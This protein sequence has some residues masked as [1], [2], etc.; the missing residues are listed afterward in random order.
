[1][2]FSFIDESVAGS[3]GPLTKTEVNW[4]KEKKGIQAILSVREGPL[5]KIWVEGLEYLNVPVKN[6]AVPTLAELN[7][8]V[9]YIMKQVSAGKKCDVHCAAGRGRT[10]T[11]LACYFCRR[12]GLSAFD[13]I[14]KIRQMRPGSIEKQQEKAVFAYAGQ[15][16]T[17]QRQ[18]EYPVGDPSLRKD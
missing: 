6:H 1:M 8:C 17:D 10:G 3:A 4:L 5:A 9:D 18:S 13:A 11:V 14:A 12:Y 16:K 15:I 2:N 7:T